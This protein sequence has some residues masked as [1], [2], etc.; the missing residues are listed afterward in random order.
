MT[1]PNGSQSIDNLHR[2]ARKAMKEAVAKAI[3]KHDAA[4]VPAAIWKNGRVAYLPLTSSRR[5]RREK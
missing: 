5:K 4:G 3:A 2:K 1:K